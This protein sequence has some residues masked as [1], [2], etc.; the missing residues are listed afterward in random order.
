MVRTRQGAKIDPSQFGEVTRV[1]EMKVTRLGS[2]ADTS[3]YIPD[4]TI[5]FDSFTPI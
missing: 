4:A 5:L 3:S 2:L 1:F